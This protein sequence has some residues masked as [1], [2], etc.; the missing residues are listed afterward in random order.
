MQEGIC[1]KCKKEIHPSNLINGMY[2]L[3]CYQG[4]LQLGK[5]FFSMI[6][7]FASIYKYSIVLA[8]MI[9]LIFLI[10]NPVSIIALVGLLLITG[11]FMVMSLFGMLPYVVPSFSKIMIDELELKLKDQLGKYSPG[12]VANCVYHPDRLGVGRCTG[13]FQ[14]FC[15]EDMLYLFK[16]PGFCRN[17]HAKYLPEVNAWASLNGIFSVSLLSAVGIINEV[18]NLGGFTLSV[19]FIMLIVITVAV[20]VVFSKYRSFYKP[21]RG[22]SPEYQNF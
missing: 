2:C 22:K 5:K 8:G 9:G 10:L 20:G 6:S 12:S 7:F 17:C 14:S 19:I 1:Y 3:E 13:C 4:T 15:A 11:F 21:Q 16:K 18:I